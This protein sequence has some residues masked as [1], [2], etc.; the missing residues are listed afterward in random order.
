MYAGLS[1]RSLACTHHDAAHV[2]HNYRR[3]RQASGM[4]CFTRQPCKQGLGREALQQRAAGIC[5][6][7][8]VKPQDKKLTSSWETLSKLAPSS[9]Q[10][11]RP[12]LDASTKLENSE[13]LNELYSSVEEV[14][15]KLVPPCP[16]LFTLAAEKTEV[17]HEFG[18]RYS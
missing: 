15:P 3:L 9:A 4:Q 6:S 5:R 7:V 11:S 18:C 16:R 2:L 12:H 10:T 14:S 13:I 17:E 1:M 8:A